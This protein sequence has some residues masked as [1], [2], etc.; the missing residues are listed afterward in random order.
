V[1][2]KLNEPVR[3]LMRKFRKT[4]IVE[5]KEGKELLGVQCD[6]I[7]NWLQH[8]FSKNCP[9]HEDNVPPSQPSE[10]RHIHED[11]IPPLE[12]S[13][14]CHIHEDSIPRLKPLY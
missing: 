8:R 2:K 4:E 1:H 5:T 12:P 6:V 9:I 11:S 13:E 14:H 7:D 10:D 3:T